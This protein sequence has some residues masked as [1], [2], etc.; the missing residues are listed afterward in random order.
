MTDQLRKYRVPILIGAG[1]LIVAL[2]SMLNNRPLRQP[3]TVGEEPTIKLR[4]EETGEVRELKFEE[5]IAGVVAGEMDPNWP[6]EALGA[7][8]IIARTFTL[9]KVFDGGGFDN[10]V[11]STDEKKL[12]AYSAEDITDNV[13]QAVNGTRGKVATHMGRV[14]TTWFHSC[15]G[16]MTAT[17]EEGLNYRKEETPYI[18]T[19][20][21]DYPCGDKGT[22]QA[23]FTSAEIAEA[24]REFGVSVDTVT[25]MEIAGRGPSGRAVTLSIN[26][27]EVNAA[28]F[29]VQLDPTRM[30]STFLTG[31]SVSGGQVT[32]A[33]KGFGHGVRMSQFG[34]KAQAEQ[35][36]TAE[37]IVQ[38]YYANVNIEKRW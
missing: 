28:D 25:S 7:Q 17:P 18:K 12:Q 33:G 20:E 8:A 4:I 1:L 24:A 10:F 23:T 31:L 34:A 26:G 9:K 3:E 21:D 6:V 16:G 14:I 5:Y 35:G 37:E 19:V 13:R 27:D 29:R 15:S 38:Y 22:W 11:A 2:L 36:K 30:R 32:M